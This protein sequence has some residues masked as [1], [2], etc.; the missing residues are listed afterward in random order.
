MNLS[1]DKLDNRY[2]RIAQHIIFWVGYI[3]FFTLQYSI[4]MPEQD[5]VSK[6]LSLSITA[7]VDMAASYFTVYFLLPKFLFKRKYFQ[8]ALLFIVS[9]A[10]AIILQRLILYYIV[11]PLFYSDVIPKYGFWKINPYYS[12]VNIYTVVGLFTAI[13]LIK[14]WFKHQ[15]L[16]VELENKSKSSELALLRSQLNPHFLFNTL[17]NIDSLIHTNPDKASDSIIKLSEMLRSVIYESEEKVPLKK[18]LDYLDNYISLQKLRLK[19]PDF[20]SYKV[21]GDCYIHKIAPMLL[22]PFVENAFKHGLK[23]KEA[24]GIV[25]RVNCKREKICFEIINHFNDDLSVSKDNT[26]GI[27]LAN[28]KRRLELLYPKNH[29]LEIDKSNSRF[30]VRLT[31]FVKS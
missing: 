17:N 15:Q 22:V 11:G 23:S 4:S 10:V 13:K 1:I 27:G 20:I 16:K 25:I 12:F 24:P 21:E 31:I 18:E 2:F 8:F 19:D 7:T 14:Q 5:N 9:A 28:T 6:I 29:V 26:H 3:A 30:L